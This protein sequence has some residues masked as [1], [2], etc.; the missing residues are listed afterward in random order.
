[1]PEK[2]KSLSIPRIG[3]PLILRNLALP[4]LYNDCNMDTEKIQ[5]LKET[6]LNMLK[7]LAPDAK[8]AWGMLNGL[9]MT[10]H[11]SDVF[12]LA[13][14]KL[15]MPLQV[16]AEQLEKMRA[17]M[18]S[19]KPFRENTKNPNMPDTPA[20]PRHATMAAAI[21]E[22]QNEI[23]DFFT[24]YESNPGKKEMNPFF[25]ELDFT[26]QVHLLHKHALHHLRQFGLV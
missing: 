8:G 1:L 21:D 16:P 15:K 11:F 19:D 5:F 13:A 14:G 17:F 26:E 10:E 20:P 18:L 2:T 7:Q 24:A 22:L 23:K 12:Q 4:F 25:G 3:L 6:F 9:Q